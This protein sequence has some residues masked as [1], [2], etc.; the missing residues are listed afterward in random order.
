MAAES[1][2]LL[3]LG[4][5]PEDAR[6]HAEVCALQQGRILAQ[7]VCCRSTACD[8]HRCHSHASDAADTA[9]HVV[10]SKDGAAASP[11]GLVYA[12]AAVVDFLLTQVHL[13]HVLT[14]FAKHQTCI[15]FSA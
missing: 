6:F 10:L 7:S 9:R 14:R 13:R 5:Q 15:T 12:L 3:R 11:K 1:E 2:A 4:M 8:E